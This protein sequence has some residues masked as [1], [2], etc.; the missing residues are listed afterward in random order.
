MTNSETK[1]TKK[2]IA[3][4][5]AATELFAEKGY[6]GTSTSEIANKAEVAEG[7]IFKHFKSKKG[8]LLSIVSPMMVKLIAPMVK[9][10]MNKVL[11]QD[12]EHFQDFIRAMIENRKAFIKKN[13]PLLRILIQEIPFHPELKEQF[14]EHIGKDIFARLRNIVEHYQA[15]GQLIQTH[16]DTIIR[17]VAS[18]IFSYIIAR[19]VIVPDGDW[20]DEE[21]VERIIQVLENG[22]VPRE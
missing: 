21:E 11:D 17:I 2:Q 14:I 22:I 13:L 6:A 18:S 20:N 16:S 8:L 5:E 9:N 3:I 12:F 4:L 1:L 7:T 19:Y 10:D 15:K